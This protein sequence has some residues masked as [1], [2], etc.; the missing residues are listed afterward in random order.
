MPVF[1][2]NPYGMGFLGAYQ[3]V[4]ASASSYGYVFFIFIWITFYLVSLVSLSLFKRKGRKD[5]GFSAPGKCSG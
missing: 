5:K 4:A 3:W 1:F 2:F